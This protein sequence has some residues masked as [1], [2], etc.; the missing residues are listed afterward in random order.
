MNFHLSSENFQPSFKIAQLY[1]KISDEYNLRT[2]KFF[3]IQ[4]TLDPCIQTTRQLPCSNLLFS[5]AHID[6]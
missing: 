5:A 6:H 3:S 2:K 1:L 4:F